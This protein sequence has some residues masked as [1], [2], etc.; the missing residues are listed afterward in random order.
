MTEGVRRGRFHSASDMQTKLNGQVFVVHKNA[1]CSSL[2]FELAMG[3]SLRLGWRTIRRM[4]CFLGSGY[5]ALRTRPNR[6]PTYESCGRRKCRPRELRS[7][8]THLEAGLVDVLCT[9]KEEQAFFG[10]R[11][12]RPVSIVIS[13]QVI[14][15]QVSSTE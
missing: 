5:Q 15:Q 4:D 6:V 13:T 7:C 11:A 10:F 12:S 9:E 3:R 1:L 14:I 8:P 2:P